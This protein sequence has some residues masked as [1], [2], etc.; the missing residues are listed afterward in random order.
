AVRGVRVRGR[1]DRLPEALHEGRTEAGESLRGSAGD[2]D[3]RA[4]ADRAVRVRIAEPVRHLQ[5]DLRIDRLDVL[6]E[7]RAV[8][9]RDPAEE[10]GLRARC[11]DRVRKGLVARLLRIPALEP[12]D[13]DP[14]LLRR[15]AIRRRDAEAV[16]L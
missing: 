8:V 4:V 1:S 14:E 15:R 5:P 16:G 2:A 3:V 6:H 11:L 9:A 13:L 7:L 10:H 12:D